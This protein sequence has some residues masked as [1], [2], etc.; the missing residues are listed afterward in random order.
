MER[1]G[2]A[3]TIGVGE[4]LTMTGNCTSEATRVF[5]GERAPVRH[6]RVPSEAARLQAGVSRIAIDPAAREDAHIPQRFRG[7]FLALDGAR[8][9]LAVLRPVARRRASRYVP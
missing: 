8:V 6:F 1:A 5:T 2:S 9:S 4:G 3:R 7:A